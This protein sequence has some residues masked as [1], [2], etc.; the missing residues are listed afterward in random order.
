M[1]KGSLGSQGDGQIDP[2]LLTGWLWN[3]SNKK[4]LAVANRTTLLCGPDCLELGCVEK[5]HRS[6]ECSKLTQYFT[7]AELKE[8]QKKTFPRKIQSQGIDACEQ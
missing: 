4:H 5:K 2:G 1:L 6:E 7:N 8:G 3:R